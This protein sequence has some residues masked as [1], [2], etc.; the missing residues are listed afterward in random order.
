[1]SD[2]GI[3]GELGSRVQ[4]AR[5]AQNTTQVALA[6]QAGVSRTVIQGIESGHPSTTESLVR[7]LRALGRLDHLDAFLPEPGLSPIQLAR[8]KGQER[9]RAAGRRGKRKT[10]GA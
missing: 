9:R 7:I 1:M 8:L 3:L 2:K 10:E 6:E 5:L 4:R